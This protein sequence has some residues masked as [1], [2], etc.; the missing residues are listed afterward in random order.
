M[1]MSYE[2]DAMAVKVEQLMSE[3]ECMYRMKRD[4]QE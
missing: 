3:N 1:R 2:K 4:L